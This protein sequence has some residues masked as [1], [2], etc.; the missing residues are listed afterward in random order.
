MSGEFALESLDSFEQSNFVAVA[1]YLVAKL[2]PR[3]EVWSGEGVDG[4]DT[5]NTALVTGCKNGKAIYL[6]ELLGRYAHQK[7]ILIFNPEQKRDQRLFVI[8]L[9]SVQ[10][11]NTIKEMR[12]YGLSEGTIISEHNVVHVYIWSKDHSRDGAIH[13]F[14]DANHGKVQEIQGTGI[15]IGN[16]SRRSAQRAFDR[17]I[18]AYERKHQPALSVLLWSR[19]LHDLGDSRQ[20]TPLKTP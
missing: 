16:E 13:A 12:K 11:A 9:T 10:S 14:A 18:A 20:V 8:E 7:W 6:G 3:L 15:L 2:C 4:T 17:G 1:R 5:E 19:K